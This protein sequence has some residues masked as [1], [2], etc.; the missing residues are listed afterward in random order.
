MQIETERLLIRR[1]AK[2]DWPAVKEIWEDFG[3]S[4][5]AQYD[6]P[7]NTDAADVRSR[8]ARWASTADSTEHMFWSVCR[9]G[10]VIGYV[11]FHH[12]D[13]H[14]YE[15]GYCFHSAHHGKGYAKESL[16]A[17]FCRLR[18]M[19]AETITAGTALRNLPSVG[20]LRSLG[21][22]QVGEEKVSFY[23]DSD[24]RDIVFDGGIFE[25]DLNGE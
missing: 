2:E 18:S 7:H 4:P 25:L 11:D 6:V 8:V 19:G 5:Y 23:K 15:T 22:R 1:T 24:G 21:F 3:A 13:G 9:G 14:R 20:L 10:V 12:I 16:S 17:L